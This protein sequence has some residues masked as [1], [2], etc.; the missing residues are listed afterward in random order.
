[1]LTE[2]VA[3]FPNAARLLELSAAQIDAVLLACVAARANDPNPLASKFVYRDEISGLYPIGVAARHDQSQAVDLALMESWERL[4]SSNII[5]QA[6]GQARDNMT[7]T[8]RG[9]EIAGA[10]NMD[11]IMSRANL[12]REMLH[13]LLRTSVYDSFATGHYDTAVRDAFVI[14]EDRVKVTSGNKGDIGVRLMR[15]A[16]NANG[17]AQTLTDMSLPLAER[18]RMADLF[19]GAIG[20]YKNPLSHRVVGNSDPQPV[21]EELMFA[22]R[23][24]R[25]LP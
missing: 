22:S 12:R 21:I 6:P 10:G 5:M 3:K 9:Q 24:L 18:E 23:L 20:T 8:A 2:L 17:G 15:A 7:L 1:M 4:K 14:V 25:Y 16:F 13:P 19:A 11:E